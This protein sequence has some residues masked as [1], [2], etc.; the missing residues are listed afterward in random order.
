MQIDPRFG[1]AGE[2][3][4]LFRSA[5]LRANYGWRSA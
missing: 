4:P 5:K 3:E 2:Q 1:D